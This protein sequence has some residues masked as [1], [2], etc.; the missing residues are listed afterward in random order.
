MSQFTD[1][2]GQVRELKL[3]VL[4]IE[5]IRSQCQFPDGSPV[6][7]FQVLDE[8][9]SDRTTPG[10]L[11]RVTASPVLLCQ[12]LHSALDCEFDEF[13][14]AMDGDAIEAAAAAL[15]D[16]LITFFPRWRRP[17]L[18]RAIAK[19]QEMETTLSQLAVQQI[20]SPAFDRE[21]LSRFRPAESESGELPANSAST[22]DPSATDSSSRCPPD[23]AA[24]SGA[25][26]AAF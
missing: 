2:R 20:N 15:V 22:L 25:G 8:V 18:Q 16:E 4:A 1:A 26:P 14:A 10:T 9:G 5:R 17:S 23:A 11:E 21:L 7:L 12:V 13:A 19:A 6:D 24:R 3:S